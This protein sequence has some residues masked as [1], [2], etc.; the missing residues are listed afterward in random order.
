[1]AGTP[2]M[3]MSRSYSRPGTAGR[4]GT[5]PP[6][7]VTGST[8]LPEDSEDVL[9]CKP[10]DCLSRPIP[11]T[12]LFGEGEDRNEELVAE[13]H[14]RPHVYEMHHAGQGDGSFVALRCRM[15]RDKNQIGLEHMQS[16]KHKKNIDMQYDLALTLEIGEELNVPGRYGRL[17]EPVSVLDRPGIHVPRD[18]K[19]LGQSYGGARQNASLI[20]VAPGP[21]LYLGSTLESVSPIRESPRSSFSAQSS[22]APDPC[23]AAE[24]LLSERSLTLTQSRRV[25]EQESCS[26]GTHSRSESGAQ[27]RSKSRAAARSRL[28]KKSKKSKRDSF[29]DSSQWL[30]EDEKAASKKSKKSRA[31]SKDE[32]FT[33]RR[34]RKATPAARG[35]TSRRG[36]SRAGRNSAEFSQTGAQTER[37]RR[38]RDVSAETETDLD[39][40]SLAS[41]CAGLEIEQEEHLGALADQLSQRSDYL[42]RKE[43]NLNK[44]Q[45]Q[46]DKRE[47]EQRAKLDRLETALRKREEEL[48][49][50]EQ[51][52]S[53][54][55]DKRRQALDDR[56]KVLEKRERRIARRTK[57]AADLGQDDTLG[58]TTQTP[59]SAPPE[60]EATESAGG[61]VR[62][63]RRYLQ[64]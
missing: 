30:H 62:Q 10:V 7:S 56:E 1:M 40:Q 63:S 43:L 35:D 51:K 31:R 54:N 53:R 55:L 22:K 4:S 60:T 45:A 42:R 33:R 37:G 29:Y 5:L 50:R 49:R 25:P 17:I 44:R 64:V 21:S 9:Q 38:R 13:L 41:R 39:E 24:S 14:R 61:A 36:K 47:E 6:G 23:A 28:G 2:S 27:L 46:M 34:K 20:S 58:H 32:D 59:E 3:S 19:Q 16:L 11:I 18:Y 57:E 26:R 15:C 52:T 48:L 8:Q 12:M